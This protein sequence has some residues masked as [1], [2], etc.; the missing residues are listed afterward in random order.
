MVSLGSYLLGALQLAL[1]VVPV[2]FSAYSL[3]KRL[4]PGWNGA[5][6]RLVE[7]IVAVALINF[8]S[9]KKHDQDGA[10]VL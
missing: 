2:A 9:I 7:S 5:P 8:A 10:T 4:L 3:R 6:A 1:V